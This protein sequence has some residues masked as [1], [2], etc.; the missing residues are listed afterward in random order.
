MGINLCY[1]YG[2]GRD[3]RL[4][5]TYEGQF[6]EKYRGSSDNARTEGGIEI[7]NEL[8]KKEGRCLFLFDIL[9]ERSWR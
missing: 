5:A 7:F 2:P 1:P 9:A 3:R 4:W 6:E 8:A